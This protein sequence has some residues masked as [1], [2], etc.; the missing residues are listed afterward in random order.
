M[1]RLTLNQEALANKANAL[2]LLNITEE[3]AKEIVAVAKTV[4]AE[5]ASN[6]FKAQADIA[7][8]DKAVYSICSLDF[9][10][11]IAE[12]IE[13]NA[14]ELCFLVRAI[15]FIIEKEI[16]QHIIESDPVL[17]NV[18]S[19]VDVLRKFAMSKQDE[20]DEQDEEEEDS[21]IMHILKI[22]RTRM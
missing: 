11:K 13:L 8:A 17:K 1:I 2:E 14:N 19:A 12:R 5:I 20:Q 9:I 6:N 21:P 16:E 7:E 22:T 4:F 10:A 3:R 15:D 18:M